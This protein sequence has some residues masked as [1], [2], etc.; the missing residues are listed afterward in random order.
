MKL[1][2]Y[3]E[4][5]I[6]VILSVIKEAF[7]EY[8]EYL[9]PPSSAEQ[10]TMEKVIAELESADALVAETDGKMVGC[11]FFRPQGEGVYVGRLSVLPG[12]RSR[13]IARAMF[14]EIE[15]RARSEGYRTLMLEVR[16]V[17]GKQLAL[18]NKLGFE[19]H[20]YGTHEGYTQPTYMKMR[21]VLA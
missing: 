21:K 1:R 11:I 16:L 2:N 20:E 10:I 5:D 19:F 8:R 4:T 17:L 12:Y 9:D 15:H 14:K 18:Y 3:R 6:P 7:A 13:G